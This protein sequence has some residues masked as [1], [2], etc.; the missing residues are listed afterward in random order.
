MR[1]REVLDSMRVV[2]EPRYLRCV[3]GR[4]FLE[5]VSQRYLTSTTKGLKRIYSSIGLYDNVFVDKLRRLD[6]SY[7]EGL[8]NSHFESM[9]DCYTLFEAD[10]DLRILE[11]ETFEVL[12]ALL[13][14][15]S[16]LYPDSTGTFSKDVLYID[17]NLR[18]GE[19]DNRY[20]SYSFLT[21][22]VDAF[23]YVIDG[24]GFYGMRDYSVELDTE[25]LNLSTYD[26][27]DY[28][29]DYRGNRMRWVDVLTLV[30][31]TKMRSELNTRYM[32][33]APA[34]V[35]SLSDYTVDDM[36]V[37]V[38]TARVRRP[39]RMV[40]YIGLMSDAIV[41]SIPPDEG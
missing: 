8:V 19:V 32:V 20:L 36:A 28:I 3:D 17:S 7:C 34:D 16:V 40:P 22:R 5:P 41:E 33:E 25:N 31:G 38:N 6:Q 9:D 30:R 18:G 39:E 4:T 2:E 37:I 26:L 13:T 15:I 12:R 11:T 29:S 27:L 21:N 10:N 1:L 23:S 24:D 35:S 14:R